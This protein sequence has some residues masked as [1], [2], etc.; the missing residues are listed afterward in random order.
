MPLYMYKGQ[1]NPVWIKFEFNTK[2]SGNWENKWKE[3]KF[4]L[5]VHT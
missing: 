5:V 2:F 3:F 4:L 1:Q